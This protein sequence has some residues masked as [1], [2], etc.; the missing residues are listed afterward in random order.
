MHLF[1]F[2]YFLPILCNRIKKKWNVDFFHYD[3]MQH[4]NPLRQA[5]QLQFFYPFRR[6]PLHFHHS[7]G[8]FS[9]NPDFPELLTLSRS[10]V[11]TKAN[12][13]EHSAGHAFLR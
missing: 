2:F 13:A 11:L 12:H 1:L 9:D 3:M 4:A 10:E 7:S 8:N 5:C 6:S